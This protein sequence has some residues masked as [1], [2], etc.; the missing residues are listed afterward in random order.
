MINIIILI[1]EWK[2]ITKQL[3]QQENPEFE[4]TLNIS[5]SI[6][7]APLLARTKHH[8]TTSYVRNKRLTHKKSRKLFLTP[9]L[10]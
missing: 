7:K 5:P 8:K 9:G 2:V 3:N 1:K 4:P 10:P 6:N